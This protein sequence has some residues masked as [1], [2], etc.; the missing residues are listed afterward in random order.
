MK[1]KLS[2]SKMDSMDSGCTACGWNGLG[3]DSFYENCLRCDAM[4][5][6]ECL[7]EAHQDT[8]A[9][10]DTTYVCDGCL[11][12]DVTNDDRTAIVMYLLRTYAPQQTEESIRDI[13]RSRG[14]L[15]MPYSIPK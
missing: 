1:K 4:I 11:D 6:D 13:L 5:C 14:E 9:K 15:E 12:D 2:F 7:P 8:D 10:G 3:S